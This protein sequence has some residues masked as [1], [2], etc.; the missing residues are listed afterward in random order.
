MQESYGEGLVTHTGPESCGGVR[1][2]GAEALTGVRAG[3]ILSIGKTNGLFHQPCAPTRCRAT[4]PPTRAEDNG[5]HGV[6]L[7]FVL[8]GVYVCCPTPGL[9]CGWKRE[10]SGRWKPSAPG[11]L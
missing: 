10:R 5:S 2:G 11:P 1:E 9:S 7:A 6:R 8:Y 4:W 3:R